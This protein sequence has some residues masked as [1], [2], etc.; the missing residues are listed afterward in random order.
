MTRIPRRSAAS[1]DPEQEDRV[2]V[3]GTRTDS[4]VKPGS[5]FNMP[6]MVK[7]SLF[8]IYKHSREMSIDR[9]WGSALP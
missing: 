5:D 6:V 8:S 1:L 2:T 9:G 7:L 4:D 3:Q